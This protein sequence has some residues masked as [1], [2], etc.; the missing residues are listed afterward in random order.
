M[1]Y[2]RSMS[3]LVVVAAFVAVV[4]L[5]CEPQDGTEGAGEADGSCFDPNWVGGPLDPGFNSPGPW[6]VTG[7]S[8]DPSARGFVDPGSAA[9]PEG[10]E[11]CAPIDAEPLS[12]RQTL[13]MPS[14]ECVGG[15]AA[16]IS[17]ILSERASAIDYRDA[18]LAVGS[19]LAPF[20]DFQSPSDIVVCLGEA[21]FHES[22]SV[23][24]TMQTAERRGFCLDGLSGIDF[25]GFEQRL[26]CP[27]PGT[28]R[29]FADWTLDFPAEATAEALEDGSLHLAANARCV[30]GVAYGPSEGTISIPEEGPSAIRATT[31]GAAPG[32]L[33]H[34]TSLFFWLGNE[35]VATLLV[36]GENLVCIPRAYRGMSTTLSLA[37]AGGDAVSN[38]DCFTP[39]ERDVAVAPLALVTGDDAAF[40]DSDVV[41]GDFERGGRNWN[42]EG[43]VAI[44]D[45][46]GDAI[47]AFSGDTFCPAGQLTQVIT[48]PHGTADGGPAL[49]FRYIASA[50]AR[51]FVIAPFIELRDFDLLPSSDEETS[52]TL[53]LPRNRA[54]QP[55]SVTFGFERRSALPPASLCTDAADP[56][57]AT[58]DDVAVG[59]S[60]DCP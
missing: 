55:L 14:L 56:I 27:A 36:P 16:R 32:S 30:S 54:G 7:G 47:A 21:A 60:P 3:K 40:C 52:G 48:I 20:P 34:E 59:V 22:V 41:D 29:P 12:V 1:R 24:V 35:P 39:F 33:G 11:L 57:F 15:A 8:Q 50:D 9:F 53:C 58:L 46:Q 31:E 17:L 18:F 28:I 49:S 51:L 44:V 42:R 45:A 26:S 4:V 10:E 43:D 2:D 38:N 25:M 23:G 5:G 6:T 37:L 19:G 13:D